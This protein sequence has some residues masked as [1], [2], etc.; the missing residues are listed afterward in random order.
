MRDNGDQHHAELTR[1][2]LRSEN[3]RYYD[4]YR[5]LSA[6][7]T[8]SQVG[9]NP[10][11]VSEVQAYVHLCGMEDPATCMKYLRLIQG[12][13]AVEIKSIRSRTKTN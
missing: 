8:W 10:I 1:P 9:P 5:S 13:D 4:A 2:A 6:G 7:R 12:M 11:Q 3:R